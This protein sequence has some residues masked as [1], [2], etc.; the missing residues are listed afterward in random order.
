MSDTCRE[1]LAAF[2]A[3]VGFADFPEPDEDGACRVSDGSVTFGFG[4]LSDSGELLVEARACA[5][6]ETGRAKFLSALARA[7]FQGQG[8]LGG[9]LAVSDDDWVVLF[10]RFQL[11]GLTAEALAEEFEGLAAMAFEWGR[12]AEAYRPVAEQEARKAE[13]TQD[14]GQQTFEGG[15]LRV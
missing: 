8:A 3:A 4:E 14:F 10:R 6:P 13:E 11:E 15:F 2:A 1:L 7:N 12:L 5:L 9:A